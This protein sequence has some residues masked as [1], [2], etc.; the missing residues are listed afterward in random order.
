MA[1]PEPAVA[2]SGRGA[3]EGGLGAPIALTVCLALAAFG[4]V[5]SLTHLILPA[6]E[7][8]PPFPS[9]HQDAETLTFVFSFAVALPLALLLVIRLQ[10]RL[11][12]VRLAG[13]AAA[14]V[15]ALLVGILALK[16]ADLV[17]AVDGAATSLVAA[18]AWWAFALCLYLLRP[19]QIVSA[20]SGI[21]A[22]DLAGSRS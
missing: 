9:Q 10:A 7:L 11:T 1:A 20:W 5:G 21:S 19:A 6:T 15:V 22:S 12:S 8:P 14:L 3:S 13:L 17:T 16:V 2:A 18:V 4:I